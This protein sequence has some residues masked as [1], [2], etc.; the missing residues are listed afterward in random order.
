[1]RHAETSAPE[2]FHGAESD[3]GLSAWGCEQAR[4][5]AQFLRDQD[6]PPCAVYSSGMRRA[7]D[8]A[9]PIAQIFTLEPRI[10]AA[11]HERKIGPLSGL[12]REEGWSVYTEA[13]QAWIAGNLDATHP[14]G[15][16]FADVRRRVLPIFEEISA[17][18]RG[19]TV[20]VVAHGIVV[21][22]VLC[23]ILPERG[24][25]D[26]DQAAIDFASIND[27]RSDGAAW[28]AER[29]NWVV[30]PSTARPVA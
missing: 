9:R 6:A 4:R 22:I 18:H 7:L 24:P 2:F 26:F 20:V 25:A 3:V 1:M 12:P 28:R 19:E 14:G 15:E 16:S 8:T 11:L 29:L 17:R 10:E 23:S 21:R 13:K 27:L 5:V 30:A